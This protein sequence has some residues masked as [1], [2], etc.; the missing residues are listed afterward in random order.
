MKEANNIYKKII[1][2]CAVAGLVASS[3]IGCSSGSDDPISP[4]PEPPFDEVD[5]EVQGAAVKGPILNGS[6]T[7]YELEPG[8]DDLKG[9]VVAT[10]STNSSAAITDLIIPADYI[11]LTSTFAA[12]SY[13]IEVVGGQVLNGTTPV[14]ETQRTVLTGKEIVDGVPIYA[15]PL[16]SM[17]LE[18][19]RLQ[20]DIESLSSGERNNPDVPFMNTYATA[21]TQIRTAFGFGL[22]SGDL[23]LRTSSPIQATQAALNYRTAIE[24]TAA[25]ISD[26]GEELAS[27]GLDNDT[28]LKL[29]ASDLTD[30]IVDGS[31]S[32]GDIDGLI[33][34]NTSN[35]LR[36]IVTQDPA[37]LIIPGTT[38]PIS[39]LDQV[40]L[41]EL[42]TVAPGTIPEALS[43]PQPNPAAG[44]IDDIDKDS[45]LDSEDLFPQN[46]NEW[47]DT[48]GDCGVIDVQTTTSGNGCG[49]NS[50]FNPNDAS[51]Q[52]I[53]DDIS[54]PLEDRN[55]AGCEDSDLDGVEDIS[56]RFPFNP[57]EWADS[58]NDCEVTLGYESEDYL[59]ETAGNDCGDNM[60]YFICYSEV[61]YDTGIGGPEGLDGYIRGQQTIKARMD[62]VEGI[63]R[64][65]DG[66][67]P[68]EAEE[69]MPADLY[70]EIP[71]PITEEGSKVDINIVVDVDNLT[72]GYNPETLS[73][74]SITYYD[75][76]V[77]GPDATTSEIYCRLLVGEA[78]SPQ[79]L[80]LAQSSSLLTTGNPEIIDVNGDGTYW[81]LSYEDIKFN[82]ALLTSLWEFKG[83]TIVPSDQACP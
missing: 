36:S 78:G 42:N 59:T 10:G 21:E 20:F 49:D 77:T 5:A 13:L 40:I 12:T 70:A 9:E 4:P 72:Q 34:L 52:T 15:T 67:A 45:V 79:D 82:V 58:D 48:D 51:I 3:V 53:C 62:I 71:T 44:G 74:S 29:V 19:A 56:D 64:L 7:I 24:A 11:R 68:V 54:V 55:A 47:A 27:S 43:A 61:T 32:Q 6:V 38:R 65:G 26:L 16:T 80:P 76:V 75:C 18:L 37:G 41:E 57:N 66:E 28:V 17:A 35:R 23:T 25:I 63:I 2:H 33:E 81:R 1:G 14:I 39:Q 22:L 73:G 8:A 60:D 30:G 50:D 46:V 69:R 83:A 31:S